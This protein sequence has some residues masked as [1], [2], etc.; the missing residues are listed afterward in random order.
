MLVRTP[1]TLAFPGF[2]AVVAGEPHDQIVDAFDP[3]AQFDKVNSHAKLCV[4]RGAKHG[5][6]FE[7]IG[8]EDRH[9]LLQALKELLRCPRFRLLA[10]SSQPSLRLPS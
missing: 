5:G 10:A 6:L 2:L 8:L 3:N 1:E 7:G 4:Y 9:I